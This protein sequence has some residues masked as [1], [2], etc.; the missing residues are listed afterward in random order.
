VFAVPGIF[1]D[2]V[3]SFIWDQFLE[4]KVTWIQLIQEIKKEAACLQTR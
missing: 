4:Y 1:A 2:E 3:N